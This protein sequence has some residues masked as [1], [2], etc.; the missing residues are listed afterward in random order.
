MAGDE[1]LGGIA[2]ALRLYHVLNDPHDPLRAFDELLTELLIA[3]PIVVLAEVTITVRVGD[4]P[5]DEVAESD[6]QERVEDEVVHDGGVGY[7][8]LVEP[9]ELGADE[10][11]QW[12]DGTV[13]E[14]GAEDHKPDK[15]KIIVSNVS[16]LDDVSEPP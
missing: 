16:E 11:Q 12:E 6:D 9:F 5:D 7:I 2:R 3:L 8:C 4:A 15:K 14:D 10:V 1:E 13:E